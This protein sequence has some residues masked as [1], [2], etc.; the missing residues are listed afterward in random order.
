MG[1]LRICLRQDLDPSSYG[2]C[3]VEEIA[4]R[5]PHGSDVLLLAKHRMADA[6]PFRVITLVSA[7]MC[8]SLRSSFRQPV[9]TCS[10]RPIAQKVVDKIR[11]V[12][13][14]CARQGAISEDALAYLL[15]WS[16][17][18]MD[19]IPRPSAYRFLQLRRHDL[20]LS[21]VADQ[22]PWC[23]PARF[24]VITVLE[25]D[26]ESDDDVGDESLPVNGEEN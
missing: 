25:Q 12:A 5:K 3:Q 14:Q 1:Q 7:E 13:P 4:N 10:R 11:K 23:R 19:L 24:R 9:G 16:D 20:G 17:G 8:H 26:Q 2:R 15:N 6:E 21:G 18:S 22:R